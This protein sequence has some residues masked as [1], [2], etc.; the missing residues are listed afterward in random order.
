MKLSKVYVPPNTLMVIL[1]M[2]FYRS[3]DPTN[4]VKAPSVEALKE[5]RTQGLGFNPTNS[6][7]APSPSLY[8]TLII[9]AY[10]YIID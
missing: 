8:T 6:V 7:K 9:V 10:Q 4:S 1:G 3:N 2:A 5:D